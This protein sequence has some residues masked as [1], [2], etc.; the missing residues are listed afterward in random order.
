MKKSNENL[1]PLDF[2]P[3]DEQFGQLADTLYVNTYIYIEKSVSNFL[4]FRSK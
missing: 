3:V 1:I 2:S 4:F